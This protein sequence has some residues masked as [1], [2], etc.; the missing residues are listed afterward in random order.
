MTAGTPPA[1]KKSS[2]MCWPLGRTLTRKGVRREMAS[3][4]SSTSL[5]GVRPAMASRWTTALVEPPTAMSTVIAF[6]S[7]WRVRILEGRRSSRT[8][9]TMRRPLSSAKA[10]RRE[11]GAGM[12]ADPGSDMPSASATM[13]IVD[14]V[15]MTVQWPALR[16]MQPSISCNSSGETWPMRYRSKILR[17]SVP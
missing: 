6:S 5:W 4:S 14:A 8:I 13:A 15:P 7:A 3:K 10:M 17:P 9:S 1:K 16:T 2:I 11:S 12:A